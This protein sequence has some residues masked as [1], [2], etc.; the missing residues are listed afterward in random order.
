MRPRR[1][2][3]NCSYVDQIVCFL[4]SRSVP[5]AVGAIG[6]YLIGDGDSMPV[7]AGEPG[8]KVAVPARGA[9]PGDARP[10]TPATAGCR[11][12]A[13]TVAPAPRAPF[14]GGSTVSVN[15]AG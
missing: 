5:D 12:P 3:V 11:S 9:G 4:H 14:G 13:R 7:Y 6:R 1:V 2:I 10:A 8:M 15:P